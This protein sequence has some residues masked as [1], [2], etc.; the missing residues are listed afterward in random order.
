MLS[1]L[2]AYQSPSVGGYL[3]DASGVATSQ[4]IG[5]SDI[6]FPASLDQEFVTRF[7]ADNER[8][9][10]H[11][12]S[13]ERSDQSEPDCPIRPLFQPGFFDNSKRVAV[14][15]TNSTVEGPIQP[16]HLAHPT[17]ATIWIHTVLGTPSATMSILP[18]H[19]ISSK[20][21]YQL[22]NNLRWFLYSAT[23]R[24]EIPNPSSTLVGARLLD[25]TTALAHTPILQQTWDATPQSARQY[26]WVTISML[27]NLFSLFSAWANR[28]P[29]ARLRLEVYSQDLRTRYAG[30]SPYIFNRHNPSARSSLLDQLNAWSIE[31]AT[32]FRP[33]AFYQAT[34][35]LAP[36]PMGF[37]ASGHTGLPPPPPEYQHPPATNTAAQ[38][39]AAAA[40]AAVAACNAAN[41][42]GR[43][44]LPPAAIAGKYAFELAPNVPED[45][46][47]MSVTA[48]LKKIGRPGRL[49][50]SQSTANAKDIEICF[51][52]CTHKARWSGC[53]GRFHRD[54]KQPSPCDRFHLDLAHPPSWLK[55]PKVWVELAAWMKTPTTAQILQP[56]AEFLALPGIAAI[57]R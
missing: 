54:N 41:G 18:E 29:A 13:L 39:R 42:P 45:L 3:A 33:G 36:P 30:A 34:Q 55:D 2:L 9:S 5:A 8:A 16:H 23:N 26:T 10:T 56:T 53:R 11:L 24:A 48:L 14:L 44:N 17:F 40:A 37:F 32:V 57:F 22:L 43:A 7:L 47:R 52:F 1:T 46:R 21:A 50:L 6:L 27:Q 38:Q 49:L 35:L 25:W 20:Q 15:R 31:W 19:G 28:M 4:I 51:A 12:G